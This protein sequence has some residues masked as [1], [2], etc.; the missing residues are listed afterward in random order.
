MQSRSFHAAS[1]LRELGE[2]DCVVVGHE[3]EMERDGN[4]GAQF[5]VKRFVRLLPIGRRSFGERLRCGMDARFVRY[6]GHEVG[7]Q[8]RRVILDDLSKYDLVWFHHLRTADVF[9]KWAW[10]KSVM[11]LDD[12]P[13]ELFRA[14]WEKGTEFGR[15]LRAKIRMRVARN[16]ERLLGE[17]FNVLCVCS[18]P[19]RRCLRPVKRV[20]VVP[21]GFRKPVREPLRKVVA[22][23]RVGFI[24]TCDYAPNA[25]SIRWFAKECWPL[26]K[27]Q[28]PDARLRLV[29]NGSNGFL[30]QMDR[31]VDALGWVDDAASEI[32]TWSLMVVPLRIGAGTR[33][34]IA[35]GFSC[36]CPIV[37]TA[38][39]AYGYE[40]SDGRELLLA[41]SPQDLAN[42]CV[43]VIRQPAEAA[44]MAE[45]AWKIF[46]EKWTW[47]AIR[48]RIH[49]A[50][51]DCLRV[52]AAA[53]GC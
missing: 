22:P 18:E 30:N 45:R 53:A 13:S 15:R 44:A 42:A 47:E 31:S 17:R 14:E 50:A 35:E 4:S 19:D 41:D 5:P 29:G 2:V 11:D 52:T 32:A 23:P 34:K 48:P 39:G 51:E 16:R 38:L 33:V 20:H 12:I 25:E 28:V 1:V 7:E 9:G 49:A 43:K 3:V 36:K 27:R 46:L 8:D 26:V 21:N 10:D 40:V 6:H 24:G 37:S